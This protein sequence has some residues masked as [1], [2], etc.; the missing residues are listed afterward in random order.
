VLKMAEKDIYIHSPYSLERAGKDAALSSSLLALSRHH[1][2][3]CPEYAAMLSALGTDLESISDYRQIPALPVGLFKRMTLSSI[4]TDPASAED[5]TRVLTSSGTTGQAV[6]RIILDSET[7]LLQQ[8]ALAEIGSD[9][10]GTE[11]LPMLVIDCPSAVRA[12]GTYSARAAGILGF[13]LFAKHR[14]FALKDDMSIDREALEE[15]LGK[16]SDR[17]FLIFGFTFMI[18][19]YFYLPF[20]E[21]GNRFDLSNG[22]L[23]HGG[24]W[25]KLA[26]L[27]ISKAAFKDA[28]KDVFGISGVHDYYGM[29]E[30][31]GS[32][33]M[34]CE[35]GHL[36]CSDR[37]A[38]IIRNPEDLSIC[39]KGVPGIIQ[40]LS[41]LPKSYPGHS[42]LT[43]DEGVLL[44]EDDCPCGR[45]GAYFE[46]TGR[47]RKAEIRGCSDTYE[48]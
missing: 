39:D 42:L 35:Y 8:Q 41:T 22:T 34:E 25:K 46:V 37:S 28:L 29:A 47:I 17:P 1:A 7:R 31:A 13:S 45:K 9:F 10:L 16:Y 32:I 4:G 33:F 12:G 5:Q 27:N 15:F 24:G 3:K 26:D 2:E 6:S 30:Q 20:R 23:I 43:E 11:R 44:G 38:V 40:V 21:S 14:T 19:Q 18:W 48:H 36:H